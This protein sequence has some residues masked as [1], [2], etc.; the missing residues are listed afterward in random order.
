MSLDMRDDEVVET[1]V[2]EYL[3]RGSLAE[4]FEHCEISVWSSRK[5]ENLQDHEI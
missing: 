4:I 5:V 2:T 3:L 1:E